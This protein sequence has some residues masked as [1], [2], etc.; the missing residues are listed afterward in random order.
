ML[1]FIGARGTFKPLKKGLQTI[2]DKFERYSHCLQ[3]CSTITVL[4]LQIYPLRAL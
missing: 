2:A 1:R 4:H 3:K